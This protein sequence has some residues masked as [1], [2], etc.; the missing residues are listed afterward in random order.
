ML[1]II[2][3]REHGS[4]RDEGGGGLTGPGGLMP[5]DDKAA[6]RRGT[7]VG[8]DLLRL[9]AALLVVFYHVFFFS[10]V[11]PR[12]DAGISDAVGRFVAFPGA[13]P[14]CSWGWVGVDLFFVISGFVIT[15]SAHGKA[16][17][18]F[19]VGR[20]ARLYPA[21][22]CFALLS[23]VI[24]LC[25]GLLPPGRAALALLRALVLFPRGPWIDGVIWTLTI[26]ALFYGMIFL[27][28]FYPRGDWLRRGGQWMLAGLGVF[29]A[30][31]VIADVSGSM[32]PLRHMAGAYW[33]RVVFISTGP[34]F[35]LGIFG[36][37]AYDRGMNARRGFCI[38]IATLIS[39]AVIYQTALATEGVRAFHQNAMVPGAVWLGLSLLC[40]GTV[41]GERHYHPGRRV[42]A[43]ARQLGLLTYP[44][45]LV[46]DIPGGFL[47]GH[48]Y[49]IGVA[50]WAAGA[51]TILAALLASYGFV[52][53]IEPRLRRWLGIEALRRRQVAQ[54]V[55]S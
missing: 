12:G 38:G 53:L 30:L 31:V 20:F 35:L 11:E 15:M 13:V 14:F 21:L 25:A 45:Y 26:E 17:L 8:L 16:P 29:W 41:I 2:E 3:R 23:F 24:V 42:R 47:L 7:I 27:T 1:R 32:A 44:L 34:F 54:T 50:R 46:H 9:C 4:V 22:L 40:A 48:L 33:A 43:V 19:A 52:A 39:L 28:L 55:F 36:Y 51:L 18:N 37:E 5:Q 6:P 10:W 49:G